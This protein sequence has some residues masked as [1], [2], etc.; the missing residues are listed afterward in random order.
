MRRARRP[1]LPRILPKALAFAIAVP[2][3]LAAGASPARPDG[4]TRAI[5]YLTIAA[6]E[7][8]SSGGHAAIRF[9]EETFH[10]LDFINKTGIECFVEI[11]RLTHIAGE[12]LRFSAVRIVT[13]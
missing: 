2:L 8:G 10:F 5:D 4:M 12:L 6:N 7:G 3:G 13:V 1:R 9:G 11:T